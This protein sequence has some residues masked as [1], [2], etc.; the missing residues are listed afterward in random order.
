LLMKIFDGLEGQEFDIQKYMF[1]YTMDS[2]GKIAFGYAMG[3]LTG[4][5]TTFGAAFDKAHE[6]ALKHFFTTMK[7][8]MLTQPLPP[9]FRTILTKINDICNPYWR[10]FWEQCRILDR[11]SYRIIQQRRAAQKPDEEASDLLGLM[12]GETDT[13]GQ[14][15]SDK[16]LRDIVLNFIIAGRDTTACTLSWL[17]YELGKPANRG[18]QE[19]LQHEVDTALG[20]GLPSYD[21]LGKM[22]YLRAVV[23]EVLRLHPIVPLTGLH[24]HADVVLPDG[25]PC[26]SNSRLFYST[27]SMGRSEKIYGADALEFKPERW[28]PFKMPSQ[29]EF[30]VFKGGPRVCLG[31]NM[32]IFEAS[33]LTSLVLQKFNIALSDGHD[34]TYGL[35]VTMSVLDRTEGK[36]QVL[37]RLTHRK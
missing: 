19:R 6:L 21:A 15:Y 32:A 27:Y 35:K 33:L 1:S 23:Y 8:R 3:N 31:M 37:V 11:F 34:Y 12:L 16:M 14:P 18:V 10:A 25:T 20:K 28:I 36:E 5:D 22:E 29:F 7:V 4:E 30:P 24:C 13:E 9:P 2:F 26:P 17:W